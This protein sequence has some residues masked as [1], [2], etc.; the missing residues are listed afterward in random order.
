MRANGNQKIFDFFQIVDF[1]VI[2]GWN[3]N[4]KAI[5]LKLARR[6]F[7]QPLSIARLWTIQD[8]HFFDIVFPPLWASNTGASAE[9][10]FETDIDAVR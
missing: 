3:G 5:T 10:V 4:L 6:I 7:C 8:G 2:H 1:K 9:L